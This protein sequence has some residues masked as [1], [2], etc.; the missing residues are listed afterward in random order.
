M[1]KI[2]ECNPFGQKCIVEKKALKEGKSTFRI[3]STGNIIVVN[4]DKCLLLNSLEKKVDFLI[5]NCDK[6][7]VL[8]LELKGQNLDD[9]A[10][11]ILK[12]KK[13]IDNKININFVRK[14]YIVQSEFNKND[15][16]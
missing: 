12:T 4:I 9:A 16:N 2:V 15:L 3:I 14:A 1:P 10:L 7:E 13:Q 6:K 8:Y 5:L 11:Q